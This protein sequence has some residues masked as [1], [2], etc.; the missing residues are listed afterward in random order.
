MENP[1]QVFSKEQLYEHAWDDTYFDEQTVMVYINELRK[2]IEDD[3]SHPEYLKTIR[4][5]GYMFA[6]RKVIEK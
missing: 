4:G 5:F 3:V 6:V 2:I 1:D